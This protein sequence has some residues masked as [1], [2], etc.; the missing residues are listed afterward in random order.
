[1]GHIIL[2]LSDLVIFREW[3][4]KS[5][6]RNAR[7][8]QQIDLYIQA[9]WSVGIWFIWERSQ[10]TNAC[11]KS[12]WKLFVSRKCLKQCSEQ[13]NNVFQSRVT[14]C[15]CWDLII[16]QEWKLKIDLKKKCRLPWSD[17]GIWFEK[18]HNGLGVLWL[19][20]MWAGTLFFF[21]FFR[22]R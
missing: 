9:S 8:F 10:R 14:S 19:R 1:M 11:T 13:F 5:I 16:F 22:L 2:F 12:V 6:W 7:Y 3:T 15:C 21:F 17:L 4:L 18:G 20:N